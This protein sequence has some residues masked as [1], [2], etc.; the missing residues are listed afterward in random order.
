MNLDAAQIAGIASVD[1]ALAQ[2]LRG[3]QQATQQA[4]AIKAE[5]VRIYEAVGLDPAKRYDVDRKTG[6]IREKE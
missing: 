4:E 1:N 3:V 2:A 6:E 5:Q